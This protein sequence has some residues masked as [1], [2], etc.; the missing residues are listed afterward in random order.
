MSLAVMA[1]HLPSQLY[2]PLIFVILKLLHPQVA[3]SDLVN[4]GVSVVSYTIKDIRDDEVQSRSSY[5]QI[6]RE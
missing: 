1:A 6:T 2:L 3:S 5:Y 4:M